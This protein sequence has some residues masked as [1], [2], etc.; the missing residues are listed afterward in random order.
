MMAN[1]SSGA[2]TKHVDVR[3]HVLRDYIVR[4]LIKPYYLETKL[5]QADLLNKTH[6]PATHRPLRALVMGYRNGIDP[7][8]LGWL[9]QEQLVV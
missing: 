1:N 3:F 4:K 7:V 2:K 5:M 6:S 9:P 8:A